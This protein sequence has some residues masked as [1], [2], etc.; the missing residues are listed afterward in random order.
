MQTVMEMIEPKARMRNTLYDL[1][2]IKDKLL[3]TIKEASMYSGIGEN[4]LYKIVDEPRCEF[5]VRIGTKWML[6]RVK[7]EKWLAEQTIL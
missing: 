3:L 7:F 1:V 6:H 2:P 5:A 4:R